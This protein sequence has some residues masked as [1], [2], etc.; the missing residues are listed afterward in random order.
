[1]KYANADRILNTATL[2][3]VKVKTTDVLF[4]HVTR[5]QTWPIF[6]FQCYERN[7][8]FSYHR[9]QNMTSFEGD[10]FHAKFYGAASDG[11]VTSNADYQILATGGQ[12]PK[13]PITP[14]IFGLTGVWVG[15]LIRHRWEGEF[16]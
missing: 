13:I 2:S 9:T 7:G 3:V 4:N 5:S 14:K 16:P 11:K 6:Q 12:T 10:E 8:N 1:M 15:V